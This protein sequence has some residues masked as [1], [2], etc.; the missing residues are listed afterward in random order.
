MKIKLVAV[1]NLKD[2]YWKDACNE[3]LKRLKRFAEVTV[4]EIPEETVAE[5]LA[6]IETAK[7][8]EGAR[9]LQAVKEKMYLLS[10]DGEQLSSEKFAEYIKED[11]DL[12][13]AVTFVIGGS[14]GTSNDVNKRA[15]KKI[16]FGKITF[17]HRLMR[18][19]FLEQLY[20]AFTI[21]NNISYHK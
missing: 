18:V 10:L 2:S 1:G 16:A 19:V 9:I 21:N 11:Y 6:Q 4:V 14:Y 15:D 13:R 20:R 17:P 12:G 3:Y 8:K 5:N 7:N